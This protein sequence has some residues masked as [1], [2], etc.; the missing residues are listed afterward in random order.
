[1]SVARGASARYR[2]LRK[3]S[4]GR[5]LSDA[6]PSPDEQREMLLSMLRGTLGKKQRFTYLSGPVTTGPRYIEWQLREGCG[7]TDGAAW[8][9]MRKQSVIDP[10]CGDLF[11]L[12]E[13]LRENG[14][15]VI[16]PGSFETG[17]RIWSQPD[18]YQLWDQVITRHASAVRFLDGWQFSA[19]CLFEFR[20]ALRNGC[21][22]LII[23][24]SELPTVAALA[25]V[26]KALVELKSGDRRIVQLRDDI[27]RYRNEIE[28]A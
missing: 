9:T 13:M 11:R 14:H 12:A 22:T 23:D 24:G 25:Q 8:A 2:Y 5:I 15:S 3:I 10:N 26:D 20:C 4:G 18:Y 16:E 1:M 21:P 19:G 28:A 7:V 17:S 27:I 6:S